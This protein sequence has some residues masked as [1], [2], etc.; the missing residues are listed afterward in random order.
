[1][2]ITYERGEARLAELG[3][4]LDIITNALRRADRDGAGCSLLDP[5]ILEGLLR[6]G[7]TTKY[8]REGLL[9]LGWSYDNPRNLARTI[10]PGR[11]FAIV[12]ATGNDRTGLADYEAGTRHHKGY[13]TERAIIA[14][15]QLTFDLGDLLPVG[16]LG[17]AGGA[18]QLTM[19]LLLF[20]VDEETFRVELSLPAA[21]NN[22]RI[23]EWSERILLPVINRYPERDHPPG[24]QPASQPKLTDREIAW[25][26]ST[27][28]AGDAA[29]P[30]EFAR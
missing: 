19:W 13:A 1:M 15:G 11:D 10:S 29:R 20:C 16:P 5:P 8:F 23:T 28:L 2:T 25:H 24:D 17:P 22:G 7:R 3:L 30:K 26:G 12:V 18:D 21:I 14:N 6:W 27:E 9:P 4:S